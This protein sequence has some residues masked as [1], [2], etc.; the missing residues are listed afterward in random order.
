MK[1]Q[2]VDE[3]PKTFSKFILNRWI[4]SKYEAISLTLKNFK[5]NL[6]KVSVGNLDPIIKWT[7]RFFLLFEEIKQN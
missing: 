3:E 6:I 7:L 1:K 2:S 4:S 5:V